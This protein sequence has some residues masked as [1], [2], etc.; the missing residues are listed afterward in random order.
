MKNNAIFPEIGDFE[1]YRSKF[2]SN[3]INVTN[4]DR[5]CNLDR[6]ESLRA[7]MK[8]NSMVVGTG[9]GTTSTQKRYA[10]SYQAT[11][12]SDGERR[13]DRRPVIEARDNDVQST[14]QEDLVV[15]HLSD[16]THEV[17]DEAIEIVNICFL[18]E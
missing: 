8:Q 11:T 18:H 17:R 14:I 3:P 4:L 9:D 16:A 13:D 12:A 5:D 10:S 7:Y 6:D 1:I 2:S 15:L